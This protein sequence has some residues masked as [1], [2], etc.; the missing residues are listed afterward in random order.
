ME[1]PDSA[2]KYPMIYHKDYDAFQNIW[3]A[4]AVEE[5]GAEAIEKI[6]NDNAHDMILRTLEKYKSQYNAEAD[7]KS[8]PYRHDVE[9]CE[10]ALKDYD[11]GKPIKIFGLSDK[12][13]R[14]EFVV[15]RG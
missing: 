13:E 9:S 4:R 6:L 2:L 11:E 8:K 15:K 1:Y 14:I 5:C 7:P 10:Q 3:L 12:G